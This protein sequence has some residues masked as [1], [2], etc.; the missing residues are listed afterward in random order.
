MMTSERGR[1]AFVGLH[2]ISHLIRPPCI[3]HTAPR[4]K[5]RSIDIR[6]FVSRVSFLLDNAAG[7]GKKAMLVACS[8]EALRVG[9]VRLRHS[10][11]GNSGVTPL[12]AW[13]LLLNQRAQT[14]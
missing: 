1:E 5:S 2:H 11:L 12:I 3:P 9:G 4:S 14:L 13:T 6:R 10:M 8:A 7:I